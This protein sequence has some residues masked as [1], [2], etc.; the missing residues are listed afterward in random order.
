[1]G[2][3]VGSCSSAVTAEKL[4][5]FSYG[6]YRHWAHM[7]VSE[8]IPERVHGVDACLHDQ[9]SCYVWCRCM[10][11]RVV[12]FGVETWSCRVQNRATHFAIWVSGPPTK[13]RKILYRNVAGLIVRVMTLET[14]TCRLSLNPKLDRSK[15]IR[16]WR[17]IWVGCSNPGL[18]LN[19]YKLASLYRGRA[20]SAGP[21]PTYILWNSEICFEDLAGFWIGLKLVKCIESTVET[22]SM[23]ALA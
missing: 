16:W 9:C 12:M 10:I 15:S 23:S 3:S 19:H 22:C 7:S 14:F 4:F 8:S 11:N 1:M 13:S 20:F 21:E 17:N 2:W 5:S 18:S 6:S